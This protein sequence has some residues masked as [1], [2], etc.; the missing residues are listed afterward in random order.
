MC[1]LQLCNIF[2]CAVV[3]LHSEINSMDVECNVVCQKDVT[4]YPE[5]NLPNLL[6]HI[7]THEEHSYASMR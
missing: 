1:S 5:K 7:D 3:G 2:Q 4:K 6:E